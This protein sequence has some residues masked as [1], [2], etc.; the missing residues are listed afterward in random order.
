MNIKQ[1]VLIISF[2][3]FLLTLCC[4]LFLAL[5]YGQGFTVNTW[6]NGVYCTG[7]T[8]EEVNSELLSRMAAPIVVVTDKDSNRASI[9]M[10]LTDYRGSYDAPLKTFMEEQNPL[11]WVD[12]LTFHREHSL[13]PAITY[14]E[15][16][17]QELWQEIPFVQEELTT[18]ALYEIRYDET[19]GYY[20][21]DGLSLRMDVD[22]AFGQL[23]EAIAEGNTQ[24]EL[25]EEECYYS[26][27]LSGDQE[28][29]RQLWEKI[30]SFQDCGLVYDMGDQQIPIAGALAAS[31]LAK[32]NGSVIL[33]EEGRLALDKEAVEAFVMNLCLEYD[34]YRK[35]GSFQSTRGDLITVKW[36]TY[37]TKLNSRAE[38]AYLMDNLLSDELHMGEKV[39]HIPSYEREGVVHGKDDIGDTY[40]EIDLTEQRMYYYQEGELLIETDVV[41]GDT[42]RRMSTPEGVNFVYNKQLNRILKGPGYA[43]PVKYWIPIRGGVGIHDATWRKEFG[44]TIYEKNG[45]HGCINT[46]YDMVS[47]LYELVEIGTPVIT[48]Y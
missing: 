18:E 39:I 36:D 42:S 9:D 15:D 24:I 7:K 11:L 6:I 38:I 28:Q 8:V 35:E 48:F 2:S 21:Y 30:D 13:M 46:P 40:I 45:S 47:Q 33:D 12:N 20:L 10:S 26:I 31:F 37:G 17:L 3:I 14:S 4:Y 19:V 34:T 16:L 29:I 25:T 44:G 23:Q 32:E 43:T 27:P 1:R 5:Y 22:K 41:T